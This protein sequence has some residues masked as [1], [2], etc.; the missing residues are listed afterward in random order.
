MPSYTDLT[1]HRALLRLHAQFV[2]RV[3]HRNQARSALDA[4]DRGCVT[5]VSNNVIPAFAGMTA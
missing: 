3:F 5:S 2:S 4:F 1:Q